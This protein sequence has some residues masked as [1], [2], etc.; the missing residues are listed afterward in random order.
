MA[1]LTDYAENKMIDHLFR[2]ATFTKPTT[3][4][5][6]LFTA[7]PTDAGGGTEVT[8]GSYARQALNPSDTNW[9]ATQGGTTGAS[10]G[11]GGAT[12]NVPEI[13]F[14]QASANWG[15]VV[16]A[17][18]MESVSGGNML[19]WGNLTASKVINSGDQ[20][21]FATGNLSVTFQ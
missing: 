18:I 14:P 1:N 4:Y 16:A 11:T 21:R 5:I 12:S 9:Y 13:A 2:A 19:L 3:L 10:S 7:A 20:F 15:T 17:A 6:A 8:G